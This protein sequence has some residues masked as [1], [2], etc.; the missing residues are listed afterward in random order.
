M[1]NDKDSNLAGQQ[2]GHS[3]TERLLLEILDDFRRILRAP[4][5]YLLIRSSA[6]LRQIYLES[7][8]ILHQVNRDYRIRFQFTINN[9]LTEKP[10]TEDLIMFGFSR[11]HGQFSDGTIDQFLGQIC[12]YIDGIGYPVKEVIKTCANKD[13]GAHFEAT[14][15]PREVR[16]LNRNLEDDRLN[17]LGGAVDSAAMYVLFQIIAETVRALNP[18][19]SAIRKAALGS[20]WKPFKPP[21]YAGVLL[22]IAKRVD[23]IREPKGKGPQKPKMKE[24]RRGQKISRRR[25]VLGMTRYENCFFDQC[26]LIFDGQPFELAQCTLSYCNIEFVGPAGYTMS[27]LQLLYHLSS[28]GNTFPFRREVELMFQDVRDGNVRVV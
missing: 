28:D 1:T 26:R 15:N 21:F 14:L 4:N 18:L 12:L 5:S 20:A 8:G 6:A 23:K 22:W 2:K 7:N 19:R 16:M 11:E 13:G 24:V 27:H 25:V 9:P 10:G 17:L 3:R